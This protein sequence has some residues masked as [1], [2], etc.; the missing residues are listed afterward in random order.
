[1]LGFRLLTISSM[2]ALAAAC[3]GAEPMDS[4]HVHGTLFDVVDAL[5]DSEMSNLSVVEQSLGAKL[6]L[7]SSVGFYTYEVQNLPLKDTTVQSFTY[8]ISL[9]SAEAKLGPL[10]VISLTGGCIRSSNVFNHY[11]SLVI[12]HPPSPDEAN[13]DTLFGRQE[14]WGYLSFGFPAQQ[15]TC[16]RTVTIDMRSRPSGHD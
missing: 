12:G 9:P 8:S 13:G 5:R 4:P 11:K 2:V 3:N 6:S 7:V 1:M 16:L 15:P 10:A 14:S